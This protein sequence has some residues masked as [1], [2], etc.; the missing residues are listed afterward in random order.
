[1]YIPLIPLGLWAMF[2]DLLKYGRSL[3]RWRF[4]LAIMGLGIIIWE[5]VAM[6]GKGNSQNPLA[7]EQQITVMQWNVRWGGRSKNSWRSM[8]QDII[9][10]QPDIAI[11]NEPPTFRLHPFLKSAK[12]EG[13]L[14]LYEENSKHN[15]LA[16]Y[17]SWPLQLERRIK[18]RNAQAMRVLVTVKN[19]PLRLLAVDGE[20]NMSEQVVLLSKPILPRWRIPMLTDINNYLARTERQGQPI[21]I[22]A[23]DFN[24]LSRSRGFDAFVNTVGGYQ[25]ASQFANGWRGTWLS[26]LP[27]LDIDHV[28]MHKRFQGIKTTFITNWAT[29]HRGQ[30][31]QF[32]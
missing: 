27:L 28:W 6:M 4:G 32:Q 14:L 13:F 3:P 24:A 16:I 5:M 8:R 17:S 26:Y 31:V 19:Q 15:P 9:K 18:F 25:L 23:G 22:I 7:S 30:V 10:Q 21:D 20:R 29:D 1:M 12:N 11:I 2:W